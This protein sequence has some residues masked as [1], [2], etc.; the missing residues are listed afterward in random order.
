[1][2][3]NGTKSKGTWTPHP[4]VGIGWLGFH[5]ALAEVMQHQN[6]GFRGAV[7]LEAK[8]PPQGSVNCMCPGAQQLVPVLV[9]CWSGKPKISKLMFP[10]VG[11]WHL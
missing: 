8:N 4:P 7:G 9:S 11:I 6:W 3:Q 10:K 5:V 2:W 1:M